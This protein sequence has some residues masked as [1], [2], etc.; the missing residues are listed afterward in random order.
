[1]Q[2]SIRLLIKVKCCFKPAKIE[3]KISSTPV[4]KIEVKKFVKSAVDNDILAHK[5]ATKVIMGTI[6]ITKKYAREPGKIRI[7]GIINIS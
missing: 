4:G 1:M 2:K 3:S 7:S 6:D 5:A